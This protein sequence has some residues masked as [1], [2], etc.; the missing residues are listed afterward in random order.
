MIGGVSSDEE[1]SA[2]VVA[3][4]DEDE[5]LIRR[6]SDGHGL[7]DGFPDYRTYVDGD[8]KAADAYIEHFGP[9]RMLREVAAKREILEWHYPGFPPEGAP[10]GL[11]ICGGEEGDGD[12]WQMAT[13]WPC[14]QIR[15]LAAIWSD[16]PDCRPE[17]ES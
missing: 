14:P 15:A 6:N 4:L 16:H 17:W 8:T 2:F 5:A 3:R 12:T 9:A 7:D 10:E 11:Q 1:I 13:P